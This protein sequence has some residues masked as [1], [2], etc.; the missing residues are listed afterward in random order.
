MEDDERTALLGR[1]DAIVTAVAE[2]RAMITATPPA[3]VE[4][5]ERESWLT[6]SQARYLAESEGWPRTY[7][8][9]RNWVIKYSLGRQLPGGGWLVNEAKLLAYL[10]AT[11][12]I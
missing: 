7:H 10:R 4:P 12:P 6:I 5:C 1:L 9:V 8:G 11:K 3:V 2:L